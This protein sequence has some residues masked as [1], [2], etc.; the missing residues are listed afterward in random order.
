[1]VHRRL[2]PVLTWLYALASEFIKGASNSF[3]V[4][5]G[6]STAAEILEVAPGV[7]FKTVGLTMAMGGLVKVASYLNNNPLP[8]WKLTSEPDTLS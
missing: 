8:V 6:G 4:V 2:V 3:F 5:S 1:M 7:G